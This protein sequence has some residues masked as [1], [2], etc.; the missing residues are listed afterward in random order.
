MRSETLVIDEHRVRILQLR[1]KRYL[2]ELF[3]VALNQSPSCFQA[4]LRWRSC[5]VVH[6]GQLVG[7]TVSAPAA[8]VAGQGGAGVGGRRM[9]GLRREWAPAKAASSRCQLQRGAPA[10]AGQPGHAASWEE[11]AQPQKLLLLLNH[12]T[13]LVH[14]MCRKDLLKRLERTFADMAMF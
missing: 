4:E 6:L 11:Q 12:P 3:V 2:C 1:S 9:G 10:P 13:A 5:Q 8:P 14:K 7:G